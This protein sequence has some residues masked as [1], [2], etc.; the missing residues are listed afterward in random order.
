MN[1][2]E[3][4]NTVLFEPLFNALMALYHV[5][6]RDMGVAI[7]VLTLLIKLL[8]FYPSLSQLKAQRRLQATQPKLREL[9]ERHKG[10]KEAYSRAVL[11]FYKENKVNPLSSCLPLLIQF[12]IL[13]ALYRVFIA[14]V[15]PDPA[16]GLLQANELVHLYG[17]LRA[18]YESVAVN[19]M[20]LGLFDVSHRQNILLAL[21]AGVA[22]YWQSR[23]LVAARP[24]RE[25]GSGGSDED[26]LAAMNK[27]TAYVLPGVVF[28]F[29]LSFPAGLGLY[30]FL[31]TLFQIAQ[32]YYVLRR[33]PLT[34]PS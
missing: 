21:L 30:W 29:S 24:P 15:V 6:G 11:Q 7:V 8:L 9:R 14:G 31:S 12:P 33:H 27:T 28:I 18:I 34:P 16:T 20:S 10:N 25:A 32:Q 22:T 2:S 17:S 26:R 23:M 1:L 13:Y 3:I 5:L 4:F 19:T